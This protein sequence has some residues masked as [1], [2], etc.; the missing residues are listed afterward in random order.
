[1]DMLD[2]EGE[3]FLDKVLKDD[4][5]NKEVESNET[6]VEGQKAQILVYVQTRFPTV[7]EIV[8]LQN[9]QKVLDEL[10]LLDQV[11]KNSV[12][13]ATLGASNDVQGNPMVQVIPVM[14]NMTTSLVYSL[15]NQWSLS[16]ISSFWVDHQYEC[17]TG[18]DLSLDDERGLMPIRVPLDKGYNSD[19]GA[20]LEG[21]AVNIDDSTVLTFSKRL[22]QAD[23]SPNSVTRSISRGKS[24]L[25]YL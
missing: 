25:Q 8:N 23:S 13:H 7:H 1:M 16:R 10:E 6:V 12:S 14:E 2:M 18:S 15:N 17:R 20:T 19:Y 9:N 24:L 4:G 21:E 22:Q 11:E 5:G 3:D